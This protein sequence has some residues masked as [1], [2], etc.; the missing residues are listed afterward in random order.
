MKMYI[1]NATAQ[2]HLFIYRIPEESQQRQIPIR[3]MSQT[4]LP[5]R[6]LNQEAIDSI[7]EQHGRY[8]LVSC[9]EAKRS[10]IYTGLIYSIDRPVSAVM[11]EFM[12]SMNREVLDERGKKIRQ[13]TAIAANAKI[14]EQL[15]TQKAEGLDA[16]VVD[17][18]MTIQEEEQ[19][20]GGFVSENEGTKPVSEGY[21]VDNK[22]PARSAPKSPGKRKI[23]K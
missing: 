16:A 6:N 8:G 3:R 18:D 12:F 7:I 5:D 2:D 21:R 10:K 15:E 23:A 22:G 20:G 9:D 19:R 13:E 14:T 4:I 17:V 1:G 11:L